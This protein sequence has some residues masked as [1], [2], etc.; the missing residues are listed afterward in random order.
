MRMQLDRTLVFAA[1]LTGACSAAPR[2]IAP[3]P[4]KTAPAAAAR[5]ALESSAA[6][7][8]YRECPRVD[9]AALEPLP[10]APDPST[11]D[12][13]EVFPRDE[14]R[15]A[16]AKP[17]TIDLGRA[18]YERYPPSGDRGSSIGI[19]LGFPGVDPALVRGNLAPPVAAALEVWVAANSARN[20]E[21]D[22]AYRLHQRENVLRAIPAENDGF[23][24]GCATAARARAEE[25]AGA[26][27]ATARDAATKIMALSEAQPTRTAAETLLLGGLL[28]SRAIHGRE[29]EASPT[30]TRARELLSG[31]ARDP[32]AP[33]ELR[34][35]AAEQLASCSRGAKGSDELI[36]A[37]RQVIAVT[38][39]P[40]LRV[41]TLIKLA[42]VAPGTPAELEKQLEQI[43]AELGHTPVDYRVA[44]ALAKL[45][46]VR[47]ERGELAPARDAAVACARATGNENLDASDAWGCAPALADALAELGGAARGA[48]IPLW[49]LARV[50]PE[51][52]SRAITRLDRDEARRVGELVLA[53]LPMADEAPHVVDLLA[54]I[55]ADPGVASALRERRARDYGPGSAWL[56]AQRAQLAPRNDLVQLEKAMKWL[57]DPADG[58]GTPPPKTTGELREELRMRVDQVTGGC[59]SE[60]AASGREIALHIDTTGSIP[61]ATTS[62]AK[63]ALTACLERLVATRFRSVGPA[64]ISVILA[65]AT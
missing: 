31:L 2:E 24:L 29:D 52:M 34:A 42:D 4:A 5:P 64:K 39:D 10:A 21:L 15:A 53:R 30:F 13:A 49:F 62:G 20:A 54:S 9:F 17:A 57:L 23:T 48:E 11:I 16:G 40:E 33:R 45:A 56:A 65:G 18:T 47:L 28:A 38:R 60:L 36:A 55:T 44:D 46:R 50:G 32:S 7:R 25:T 14:M 3:V 35:R 63:G 27:E 59:Q 58:P 1:L 61:K 8:A 51:I 37:L 19:G 41:D 22:D 12:I 6:P 43:L 26:R